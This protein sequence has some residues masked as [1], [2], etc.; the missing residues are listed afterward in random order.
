MELTCFV[1]PGWRPAIRPASSRRDWMDQSPE[2]FAYRCLPLSIAN[3][4]GWEILNPFGFEAIWTGG[5]APEDVEVRLDPGADPARSA[6]ALFGL[7]TITFHV[8]GLLRTPPGWNLWVG[9]PPNA[10]KDG[11]APLSGII[12]T[13]WS[14]YSFTMNWRLTRPGHPVRFERDEPFAHIFPLPRETLEQVAPRYAPIDEDPALRARFEAWSRS[15][16]AFQARMKADPPANPSDKWQKLY[17]RG[18]DPDGVCPVADHQAK[19]RAAPFAREDL[20]QGDGIPRDPPRPAAA[21]EPSARPSGLSFAERKFAWVLETLERQ[22]QLSGEASGL[23]RVEGLTGQAFLDHHYALNRPVI[24]GGALAGW[25]A[26]KRWSPEGLKARIGAQAV[27][28]Q[29]GRGADANFERRKEAHRVDM[30]FDAFVDQVS[31]S[32]GGNDLYLTAYNSAANQEALA[33]LAQD[34]RVLSAYLDQ[35]RPGDGAMIWIGPGG[36]FTPLH[37][38][39]TNN[40]LLQVIGRKKVVMAP[41][42]ATPDLYNDV[43]VFSEV[44]DVTD[45]GL[46]LSRYERLKRVRFHQFVL[47]PGD[48]LF[49]PIGWWH[50]VAALE[51]SVSITH[52]NFLWPNLG[53]ETHPAA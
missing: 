34:M 52:T 30:A 35:A 6:V 47:E 42:T 8:E 29:A 31:A 17:Y 3:A 18:L 13:D 24:L 39:L 5:P 23:F 9:G 15:R 40:L 53:H 1:Y 36:T 32:G 21:P 26:L 49:I 45:P 27:Q 33:P 46:D 19:L 51:F 48:A 50:Q 2:S 25:P 37:H 20:V 38:D 7:G 28:V 4:H 14:P 22:R 11:A 44:L 43:H 41:P 16:D 12:E 10:I